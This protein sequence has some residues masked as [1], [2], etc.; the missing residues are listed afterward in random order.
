MIIQFYSDEQVIRGFVGNQMIF[1]ATEVDWRKLD[2]LGLPRLGKPNDSPWKARS[3]GWEISVEM[4][5]ALTKRVLDAAQVCGLDG[6]E[7]DW[8]GNTCMKC[9]GHRQ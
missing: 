6:G 1:E 2:A 4:K 9:R 5:C 8:K 3:Y 7:H